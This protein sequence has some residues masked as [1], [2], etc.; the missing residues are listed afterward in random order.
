MERLSRRVELQAWL[1][2]RRCQGLRVALVPT[3]GNLHEGHLCLVDHARARAD[4]V[5]TSIFVNPAQFGPGEDYECY[6]RTLERDCA[7]LEARGCDAVFAPSVN[8]IY[9]HGLDFATRLTVPGLAS[10]LCGA[11]RPGHFDGVC[12]VVARLFNLIQPQLAVFGEKDRQQLMIIQAMSRDLGYPLEIVSV[13]TVRE[14]DGLAMSSR[15][16]Y[17]STE[18]RQRAPELYRTLQWMRQTLS[19]AGGDP[20]KLE[21][22]GCERLQQSGFRV[23]YLQVCRLDDLEPISADDVCASPWGVFAAAYL[24][25]ARLIDNVVVK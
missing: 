12:I 14:A 18:E 23:D 10:K 24:G 3:M 2:E 8:E 20:R 5:L 4:V 11:S 6:P 19:T 1:Q 17:L 21:Q 9:P 13:P 22:A 16:Q 7:L 25:K 15:N